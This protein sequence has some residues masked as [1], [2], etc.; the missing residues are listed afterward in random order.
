MLK[1]GRPADSGWGRTK[2]RR[3]SRSSS[4]LARGFL[5]GPP[6]PA[7]SGTIE[8]RGLATA[9]GLR[10]GRGVAQLLARGRGAPPDPVHRERARPAA[11][12]R[13]RCPPLRP[14]RPG[15]AADEGRRA[16]VRLCPADAG[17]AGRGRPG[18]PAVPRP[19]RRRPHRGG[20]HD[21]RRVRPAAADR[22]LPREVPPGLDRAADLR[23]PGDRRG[24][25]GRPGGAGHGRSAAG[26]ADAPGGRADARRAGGG[27]P[28]A[29]RLG[30][31]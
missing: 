19:G 31:P 9:R 5:S 28:A 16:V 26:P 13:G 24:G 8:A 2:A 6:S 17:A 25:A 11:R 15:D 20:E 1:V 14:P 29:A 23:H 12:G 27:R 7:T 10:P 3:C 4:Q 30:R 22:R 21:P 18:S